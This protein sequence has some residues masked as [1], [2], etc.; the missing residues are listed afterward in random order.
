ML[1]GF[2]VVGIDTTK[3]GSPH[4]SREAEARRFRVNKE[5]GSGR[6]I[7]QAVEVAGDV[8]RKSLTNHVGKLRICGYSEI[9]LCD[10]LSPDGRY[11]FTNPRFRRVS[12]HG[13]SRIVSELLA[14]EL[15][16][17]IADMET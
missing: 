11:K 16:S 5:T 7:A 4:V 3:P 17:M 8:R 12:L 1:A 10:R 6:H 9:A 14:T 13:V 2:S 15:Q